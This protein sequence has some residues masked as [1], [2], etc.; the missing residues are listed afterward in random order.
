MTLIQRSVVVIPSYAIEDIPTGLGSELAADFLK[1]WTSLWDPRLLVGLNTLPEWKRTDSSSLDLESALVLVPTVCKE[2]VDQ[3]QRERLM[4]GQCVTV[5][6]ETE[7]LQLDRAGLVGRV[8]SHLESRIPTISVTSESLAFAEDFFALG[9]AVLQVQMLA[10]KLRY[11]WN[12]DWV[13]FT[14]QVLAAAQASV[15]HNVQEADRLIQICFDTVSQERDRYCSQQIHLLDVVLLADSTLEAS[16]DQQWHFSHPVNLLANNRLLRRL[17]E[18]NPAGFGLLLERLEAKQADV[19][20]GLD[21]PLDGNYQSYEDMFHCFAEGQKTL[22]QLG[23]PQPEVFAQ[24]EPGVGFL[25]P[26]LL[27]EFGYRGALV[28]A[29][30]GGSIPEKDSAKI[31]WQSHSEGAAIDA[32]FG[33]VIDAAS[34]EAFLHFAVNLSKQLDYHHVPTLVLAHWP[35][36]YGDSMRDLLRVI[37]RSPALG[38][39]ETATKYFDTTNQPYSTDSFKNHQFKITVPIDESERNQLAIRLGQYARWNAFAERVRSTAMLWRHVAD[40]ASKERFDAILGES[41]LQYWW[42]GFSSKAQDVDRSSGETSSVQSLVQTKERL[43]SEIAKISKLETGPSRPANGL[44]VVNPTSHARRMFL[45]DVP[46]T[47]DAASSTRI[48]GLSTH[49]GFSQCVVDVP[50]FGFVKLAAADYQPDRKPPAP[51]VERGLLKGLFG[52]R[53]HIA[54]RNWTLVNEFMELQIDPKRGHL[55]SLFVPG[56]RGSRMSGMASL[57]DGSPSV[58]HKWRETDFLPLEE[59]SLE[60]VESTSVKGCIQVR[61]VSKLGTGEKVPLVIR[62]T[63]WKGS[64]ALEVQVEGGKPGGCYPVWRTAWHNDSASINTWQQGVKGKFMAALQSLPDL[65]EIDDIEHRIYIATGGAPVHSRF[66]ARYLV[67]DCSILNGGTKLAI[68]VNWPKPLETTRDIFDSPWTIPV[69]FSEKVADKG[70]WLAQSSQGNIQIRWAGPLDPENAMLVPDEKGL[71]AVIWLHET[72]GKRA[73]SKLSFFRNVE[74]AW[75]LK[76]TGKEYTELETDS[77]AISVSLRPYEYCR[78]GL[79]WSSS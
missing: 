66:D 67:T 63:L 7:M 75:R 46:A 4:V 10:K 35:S 37:A 53:Q 72:Q 68:G 49:S 15:Q 51:L 69:H 64:R 21:R 16:F 39:F 31:R 27:V 9:Y 12:L 36:R 77:G 19:L 73:Q 59:V 18:V 74:K 52:G 47:I 5:D 40:E 42:E 24:F 11:S 58:G 78:V 8:M 60:L 14:E 57:V 55:R 17:K 76:G 28:N 33:H 26:D 79:R 41:C 48:F 20:G 50:P 2:K 70:A 30:T 45:S 23:L 34:E 44:L 65:I 29:W 32:I 22:R 56:L 13:A 3:P 61:G 54:D 62:Y 25:T 6:S 38:T 1:S 71:D 43:L